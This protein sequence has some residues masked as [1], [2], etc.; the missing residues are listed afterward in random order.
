MNL[1]QRVSSVA[2]YFFTGTDP[3]V[4]REI[5]YYFREF[6]SNR[7]S[8]E[9]VKTINQD[10][11]DL[12]SFN[13]SCN[14]IHAAA[15]FLSVSFDVPYFLLAST[16]VVESLRYYINKM[17]FNHKAKLL[18]FVRNQKKQYRKTALEEMPMD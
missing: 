3:E 2:R 12:I 6:E 1:I 10:N 5:L 18:D 9:D 4:D 16:P 11:H 13:C 15:A 17:N 14:F 8:E 7:Q